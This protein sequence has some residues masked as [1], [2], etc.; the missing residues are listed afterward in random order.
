MLTTASQLTRALACPA[1]VLLPHADDIQTE[2]S[3]RGTAI[4]ECAERISKI[5]D[6]RH[7]TREEAVEEAVLA[8]WVSAEHRP[9]IEAIPWEALPGNLSTEIPY[10]YDVSTGQAR[11][12]KESNGHRDYSSV[13]ATEIAGTADLIGCNDKM[14]YV[15]DI[16]SG[17]ADLG[18]PD[19]SPQLLLPALVTT[20]LLD[21][22]R[23]QV[24]WV[25]L[26][27]GFAHKPS[28]IVDRFDL[29]A[30]AAKLRAWYYDVASL[31]VSTGDLQTLTGD[32]G[33]HCHFCPALPNC[34]TK[35]EKALTL[36]DGTLKEQVEQWP[37]PADTPLER[38]QQWKYCKTV[39][40]YMG[41]KIHAEAKETPIDLDNGKLWGPHEKL[42]NRKV[43]GPIAMGVLLQHAEK[44]VAMG[45]VKPT[46]TQASI[47]RG[48]KGQERGLAQEVIKK[49]EEA[50]GITRKM[51]T[52]YGEYEK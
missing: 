11:W 22:P 10:A 21:L 46:V 39:V 49:I 13:R 31:A 51:T 9:I 7:L 40:D 15:G 30:F 6:S 47:K 33:D 16:K 35:R 52:S 3:E 34:P 41:R 43:D 25:R 12:L 1:S 14:A 20:Q 37:L 44:E 28:A 42:G 32:E 27:E 19:E 24:Q 45:C 36:A 48:L 8:Q 26:R 29:D 4:H 2:A 38:F 23:C 18:S 5:E 17:W 50:G